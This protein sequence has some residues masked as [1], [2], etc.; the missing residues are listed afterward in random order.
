MKH[1]PQCIVDGDS[2]QSYKNY[3]NEGLKHIL[4]S[5]RKENNQNGFVGSMT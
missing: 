3:Y 4:L 2:I 1:Y 5:G